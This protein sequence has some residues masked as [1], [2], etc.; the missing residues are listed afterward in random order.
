MQVMEEIIAKS[1]AYRAARQ[2]QKEADVAA[3]EKLDAELKDLLAGTAMAPLL[4][5]PGHGKCAPTCPVAA[6]ASCVV[7]RLLIWP[8][9]G[10]PSNAWSPSCLGIIH[11]GR[12]LWGIVTARACRPPLGGTCFLSNLARLQQLH[13]PIPCSTVR[14]LQAQ[15]RLDSHTVAACM[16]KICHA[17]PLRCSC[18][19]T[20]GHG[21]RFAAYVS[22]T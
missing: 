16:L 4:K 15:V 11:P 12:P 7:V 3:T 14:S 5:E 9:P 17:T 2:Q 8:D 6:A 22:L 20:P 10:I 21:C 13:L 18:V 19:H 1:R